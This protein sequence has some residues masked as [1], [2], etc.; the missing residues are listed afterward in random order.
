MNCGICTELFR[1]T[2]RR[3]HSP[4]S[5]KPQPRRTFRSSTRKLLTDADA[6][7]LSAIASI[8]GA[9]SP[10]RLP[11][12]GREVYQPLIVFYVMRT[13]PRGIPQALGRKQNFA[14]SHR[15]HRL[16]MMG[17]TFLCVR[18]GLKPGV[19]LLHKIYE[20]LSGT[21]LAQPRCLHQQFI[22]YLSYFFQSLSDYMP[23]NMF[24][25]VQPRHC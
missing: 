16:I 12:H 14:A 7:F 25:Q 9:L 3:S 11:C 2:V 23:F 6:L 15:K 18:S 21:G 24:S 10:Q 8:K 1:N 5:A 13:L 19:R 17:P 20:P 4:S 22:F